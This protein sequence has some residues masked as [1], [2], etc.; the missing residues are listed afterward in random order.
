MCSTT[1]PPRLGGQPAKDR[2]RTG[3]V[4]AG[5]DKSGS[6]WPPTRRIGG[7]RAAHAGRPAADDPQ[8]PPPG[9]CPW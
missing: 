7:P 1:G 2:K 5:T 4:P 8:R 9:T 3:V 6:A